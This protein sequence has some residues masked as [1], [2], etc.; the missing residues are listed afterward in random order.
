[1]RPLH[2]LL[3]CLVLFVSQ[4]VSAELVVMHRIFEDHAAARHQF[5]I[6]MV[7]LSLEETRTKYGDY[8][9]EP[10]AA[11][12]SSERARYELK[13]NTYPN[14]FITAGDIENQL[15]NNLVAINFPMDLGTLGYRVCFVSPQAKVKVSQAKTIKDL[16]KFTIGQGSGW[17]DIEILR[18]NGFR[19]VE[20]PLQS[21]LL[22]MVAS[23]RVDLFCRGIGELKNEY[24]LNRHMGNLEYDESFALMYPFKWNLYL[25]KNNTLAKERIEAGLK[26]ALAD[27]SLKRLWLKYYKESVEFANLKSRKIYYLEP[28]KPIPADYTQYYIDPLTL[29]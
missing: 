23:G 4:S 26:L 12:L 5:I 13:R 8:H 11:I 21:S 27:G 17:P 29:N 1:M 15:D 24:D 22:K 19:V 10:L 9:L 6:E 7:R 16:Q 3:F 2:S 20:V 28:L 14:L 25:N 18:H